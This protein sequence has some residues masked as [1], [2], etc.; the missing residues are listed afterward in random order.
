MLFLERAHLTEKVQRATPLHRQRLE[1]YDSNYFLLLESVSLKAL[2]AQERGQA[3]LPLPLLGQMLMALQRLRKGDL[4]PLQHV[5][6]EVQLL[7]NLQ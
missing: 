3:L 2:R 1:L 4:A 5:L 6:L 7:H